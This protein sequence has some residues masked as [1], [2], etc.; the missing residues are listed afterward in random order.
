VRAPAARRRLLP[1]RT[2]AARAGRAVGPIGGWSTRR[3]AWSAEF[4]WPAGT[5]LL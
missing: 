3:R 4:S 5:L 1:N 2:G